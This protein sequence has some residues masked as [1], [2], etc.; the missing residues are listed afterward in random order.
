MVEGEKGVAAVVGVGLVW[1]RLSRN[2]SLPVVLIRDGRTVI[3][4]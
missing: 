4:A 1:A 3:F 2:A